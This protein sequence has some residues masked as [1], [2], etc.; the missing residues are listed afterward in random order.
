MNA[1]GVDLSIYQ[2]PEHCD[3]A[4]MRGA[5]VDFAIARAS[6]GSAVDPTFFPHVRGAKASGMLTGAYAFLYPA[7]PFQAQ[8]DALAQALSTCPV[9]FVALDCEA[10]VPAELGQLGAADYY[11]GAADYC[12]QTIGEPLIYTYPFYLSTWHKGMAKYPLWI[13]HPT[14]ASRPLIPGPWTDYTF[15]QYT[16]DNVRVQSVPGYPGHAL[17]DR[18]NGDVTALLG[19]AEERA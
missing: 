14:T 11:E 9:D 5:G 4:K 19:W 6:I 8:I 13:S 18:F 16:D 3:W 10:S 1:E 2:S 17:R 15:W 12:A 7:H